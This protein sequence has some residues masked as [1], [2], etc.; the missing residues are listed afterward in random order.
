[1]HGLWSGNIT[2][3]KAW[4]RDLKAE[5]GRIAPIVR[6]W[7]NIATRY[8]EELCRLFLVADPSWIKMQDLFSCS[9]ERILFIG[10]QSHFFLLGLGGKFEPGV[11]VEAKDFSVNDIVCSMPHILQ[12][13]SA[14]FEAFF[15]CTEPSSNVRLLL[16]IALKLQLVQNMLGRFSGANWLKHISPK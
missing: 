4:G 14:K 11:R 1:M 16:K 6:Q 5:M 3:L 13:C 9:R 15:K 10:I 12:T 8:I 7:I 2:Y